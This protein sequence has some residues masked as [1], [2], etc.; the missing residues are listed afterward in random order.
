MASLDDE[1]RTSTYD[2]VYDS[3]LTMPKHL[4]LA[5]ATYEVHFTRHIVAN[6][7]WDYRPP[8]GSESFETILVGE[9]RPELCGTRFSAKGNHYMGSVFN[10]TLIEDK[11][12]V[13]NVL[14]LGK[15]SDAPACFGDL[16]DNQIA[17]LCDVVGQDKRELSGKN[18]QIKEWTAHADA[19]NTGSPDY[20]V[21]VTEP[22]YTTVRSAQSSKHSK[23]RITKKV[24]TERAAAAVA[25]SSSS[26]TV[27]DFDFEDMDLASSLCDDIETDANSTTLSK[28]IAN[29]PITTNDLYNPSVLPDYGGDLFKHVHAKLRQLDFRDVNDELIPPQDWYSQLRQGTLVMVRASLHAFNWDNRR[30]YQLNAHTVRVLLPSLSDIEERKPTILDPDSFKKRTTSEAAALVSQVVLG[31]RSRK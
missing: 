1:E 10:P 6:N 22:M 5:Q 19:G 26:K 17:T 28:D 24:L 20:I 15:P 29:K 27:E 9:I 11:T 13:K 8:R 16:F 23:G 7:V 12:R 25:A 18:I 30:V 2:T 21:I 31:K 14:V 4:V 3:L